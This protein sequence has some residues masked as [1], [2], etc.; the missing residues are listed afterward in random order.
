M[1]TTTARGYGFNREKVEPQ[2]RRGVLPRHF[3]GKYESN[4]GHV[5]TTLSYL[6]RKEMVSPVMIQRSFFEVDGVSA[7]G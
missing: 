2:P 5:V 1:R 6:K 3:P 7:N 4:E